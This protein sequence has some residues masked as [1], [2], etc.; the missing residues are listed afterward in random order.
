MSYGRSEIHAPFAGAY[1]LSQMPTPETDRILSRRDG[2][3]A[4]IVFNNPARHNAMSLTMWQGLSD[5]LA[6]HAADPEVRVVVLSGAGGRAFVSGADISEFGDQRASPEAAAEYNR[7]SEAA[8]AAVA[9]FPKPIV[10]KIDGYCLG[11]G[12]GLAIA[13][14]IRICSDTSRFSVPAGKLGLGYAFDGVSKLIATIGPAAT[15]ELFMTASM[16]TAD[17]A[18][19]MGLVNRVA[20]T[21]ALDAETDALVGAIAANAPLTLAAFKAAL[22]EHGKRFSSQDYAEGQAAFAARRAPVFRGK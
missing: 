12:V 11:G 20:E 9:S 15:A 3:V 1:A 18:A 7:I 14:D 8:E 17:E 21:G 19:R 16:F 2:H 22:L 5:R 6:E 10:A 4:H 13:C